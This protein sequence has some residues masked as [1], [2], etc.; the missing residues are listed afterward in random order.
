VA[1]INVKVLI[2]FISYEFISLRK[3]FGP[4]QNEDGSMDSGESE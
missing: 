4:V 1:L 3:I 2:F